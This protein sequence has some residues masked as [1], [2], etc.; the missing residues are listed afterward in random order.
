MRR[1]G[2]PGLGVRAP[3]WVSGLGTFAH[4]QTLPLS[5]QSPEFKIH[6][7]AYRPKNGISTGLNSN[8][9]AA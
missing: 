9:I 5:Y 8:W 2:T 4:A 6:G 7:Q 3:L 1:A